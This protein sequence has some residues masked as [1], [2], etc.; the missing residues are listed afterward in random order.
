MDWANNVIVASLDPKEGFHC[1]D[2]SHRMHVPIYVPIVHECCPCLS[3]VDFFIS[4]LICSFFFVYFST[5]HSEQVT[6]CMEII[7]LFV[8]QESDDVHAELASCLLQNLTKEAQ[9]I[10]SLCCLH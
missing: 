9:V 3:S 10:P 2:G 8:I 7:M 1:C 5:R 4:H 6:H